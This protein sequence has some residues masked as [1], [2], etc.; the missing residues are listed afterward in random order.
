ML[1]DICI[2]EGSY[3][4]YLYFSRR[5]L[6]ICISQV[7]CWIYL[8]I[9][10]KENLGCT[11]ISQGECWIFVL[12]KENAVFSRKVIGYISNG[13]GKF[14]M[15]TLSKKDVFPLYFSRKALDR[16]T[17]LEKCWTKVHLKENTLFYICINSG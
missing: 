14:L 13:V 11:C 8:H 17:S 10:L 1:M 6:D 5:M 12:V 15:Y 9:F 7:K 2:S 3:F 4:R 16:L